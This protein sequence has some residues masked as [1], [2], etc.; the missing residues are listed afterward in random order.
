[1]DGAPSDGEN[2]ARPSQQA[3]R[4]GRPIPQYARDGIDRSYVNRVAIPDLGGV[5]AETSG[6]QQLRRLT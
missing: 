2:R 4:L 5:Y 3:D 6:R 1:M